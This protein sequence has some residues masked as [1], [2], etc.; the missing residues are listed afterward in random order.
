MLR[1]FKRKSQL[2]QSG[3]SKMLKSSVNLLVSPVASKND[4]KQYRLIKLENGL[5]A[6]LIHHDFE[7]VEHIES[8]SE[9]EAESEEE[10]GSDEEGEEAEREKL[11]AVALCIGAGS[12]KDPDYKIEG[13]AH[14][15]G[16]N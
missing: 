7:S 13:L 4:K 10:E 8:S 5:K 12:F 9:G 15:V 6:L 2:T 11:A 14:F 16:K 1:S 3:D